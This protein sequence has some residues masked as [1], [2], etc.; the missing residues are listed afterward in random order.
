MRYAL[1]RPKRPGR[2]A[3]ASAL[4]AAS[5][6]IA[7]TTS[8]HAS[9]SARP[10]GDPSTSSLVHRLDSV[11]AKQRPTIVLVHG[12]WAD[13]SSWRGEMD[14]LQA[15]GYSVRAAGNPLENLTTDAEFVADFLKTI[16]G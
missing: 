16:P 9:A 10:A 12:A 13:S 6:G 14:T 3:A 4:L 15:A 8:G 11:P 7:V 2:W 1:P 5:A